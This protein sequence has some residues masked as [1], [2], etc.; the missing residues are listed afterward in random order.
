M[1]PVLISLGAMYIDIH[2]LH[3][4][5]TDNLP[6]EKEIVG[7]DY[8]M[9][10]GGSALGFAR[11]CTVLNIPIAFIGKAGNDH[12]GKLLQTLVKEAG[13]IP[14]F[15]LSDGVATNLALNYA[16]D[17]GQTV[18][19][20]VGSAN[21][22]LQYE[23]VKDKVKTLSQDANY[24]YLGGCFKL[25]TLLPSL[26]KII[27]QA[28]QQGLQII[29]DHGRVT[30]TVSQEEIQLMRKIVHKV[31]YYLP[32]KEEFLTVWEAAT[33]EEGLRSLTKQ[34]N[35]KVIVKDAENGAVSLENNTLMT[36]PSFPITVINPVAAGDSFNAGF[37][38]AQID[39][40]SLQESMRFANAT[41]ALKIST[42][43]LPTLTQ[44][45]EILSSS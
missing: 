16:N 11:F 15:T 19:T 33:I 3:F 22:S 38:K 13:I 40:L 18:M 10:P 9:V 5:F 35:V 14:A 6:S 7:R 4:P 24:L 21:Q 23:D 2:S 45:K 39:G 25:K 36:V 8:E 28:K 31:D 41:A 29:L 20:V 30:N 34:T 27:L 12:A 42:K 26:L 17:Q 1:K 32:S 37:M 43:Q 44:I